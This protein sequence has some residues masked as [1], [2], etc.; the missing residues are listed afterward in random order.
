V[1]QG[2]T[3]K[4]TAEDVQRVI[5][6]I[7]DHADKYAYIW[8]ISPSLVR[9]KFMARIRQDWKESKIF[10]AGPKLIKKALGPTPE[11]EKRD[12]LHQL[13]QLL[14]RNAGVL[15]TDE[16]PQVVTDYFESLKDIDYAEEGTI[17]NMTF[18]VPKGVVYCSGGFHPVE[19]DTPMPTSRESYLREKLQLPTAL[20][21]GK[22]LLAENYTVCRAGD[23]LT[24]RQAKLLK[25]FLVP[26]ADFY[27]TPLG[28]NDREGNTV[29]LKSG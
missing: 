2:K 6:S 17:S 16:P 22:V 25:Q 28:Y 11:T 10:T 3:K 18:T 8:V 13:C 15:M 9:N 20:S 27:V 26:I 24:S 29:V 23:T 12:N 5:D 19:E 7:S 21:N 4:K 1:S 14:S